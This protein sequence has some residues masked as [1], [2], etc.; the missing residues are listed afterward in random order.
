MISATPQTNI[1]CPSMDSQTLVKSVESY[2]ST[3][4]FGAPLALSV[5]V[6]AVVITGWVCTYVSMRNKLAVNQAPQT[7]PR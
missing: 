2:V 5:V 4:A 6:L 3:A 1:P 7:M